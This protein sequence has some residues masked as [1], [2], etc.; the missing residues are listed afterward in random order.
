MIYLSIYQSR[1]LDLGCHETV[2]IE[3]SPSENKSLSKGQE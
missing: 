2:T 1:Y 3:Y